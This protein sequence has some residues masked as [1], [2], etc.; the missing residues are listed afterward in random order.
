MF[1]ILRNIISLKERIKHI[2]SVMSTDSLL[3]E[4]IHSN[5][6]NRFDELI[7]RITDLE[8]QI[9]N[10]T[11]LEVLSDNIKTMLRD[12][13]VEIVYKH[14]NLRLKDSENNFCHFMEGPKITKNKIES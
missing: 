13:K 7:N 5:I 12:N 2:E 10:G 3:F 8:R 14:G 11:S 4:S 1:G 6:N 9:G